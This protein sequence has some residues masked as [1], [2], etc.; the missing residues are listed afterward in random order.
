MSLINTFSVST[1]AMQAQ[2]IRL[3]TIASNIANADVSSASAESAY[4]AKKVIFQETPL[5]ASSTVRVLDIQQTSV[6]PKMKFD[7]SDPLANE[8]GMVWKPA[9]DLAGEMSDMISSSRAYQLNAEIANVTRAL[10]NRA[11]AIGQ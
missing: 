5:Q 6:P 4:K 1:K 2:A 10:V 8:Q 7:P 3:N 9:V 11:L